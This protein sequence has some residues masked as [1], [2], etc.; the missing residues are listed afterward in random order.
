MP[1]P[2]FRLS[3]VC[4]LRPAVASHSHRLWLLV[5]A[6]QLICISYLAPSRNFPAVALEKINALGSQ[7]HALLSILQG[8]SWAP[9]VRLSALSIGGLLQQI[10]TNVLRPPGLHAT[11]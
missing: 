10:E 2:L 1:S 7:N 11:I 3:V 9:G 5:K 8:T 6:Q 4:A